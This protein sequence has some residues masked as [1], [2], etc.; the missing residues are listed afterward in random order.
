MRRAACQLWYA[1]MVARWSL[2]PVAAPEETHSR[3]L[4]ASASARRSGGEKK[5]GRPNAIAAATVSTGPTHL[6]ISI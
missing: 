3:R 2:F 6:D 5:I 1:A 4:A